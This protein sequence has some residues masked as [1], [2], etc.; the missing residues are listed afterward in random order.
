MVKNNFW[1]K[2]KQSNRPI[3]AL[4]PMAGFT[5]S[6]FRR[7]CHRFGADVLYSEM[8][9]ATALYYGEKSKRA[10][11]DNGA[12]ATY[13]LLNFDKKQ[14]GYYVV[15]LF[16]SNPE[17][18]AVAARLVTQKIKP[19]GID[20][21]FGCPAGKVI[22]Q[23]AGADLMKDLNR[24]R[25]VI[26]AVLVNTDLPVSV[27]IRARSADIG[28]LDFLR[29]I[30]DLP[31]A[32]VMIHGRSLSQGFI[33]DPDFELIKSARQYFSGIILA[34]GGINNLSQAQLALEKSAADGLGLARGVLGRPWLFAEIKSGRE[35]ELKIGEVFNLMLEQA[36]LFVA[37]KG[38]SALVEL[39]KHLVWYVQG[40]FGATDL[41][42]QL[43]K[44][45]TLEDLR[46]IIK[47]YQ[48]N[49]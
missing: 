45:N 49:L 44:I 40:M 23:G 9:S 21:N 38:E 37:L 1:E 20:I 29:H 25:A 18:F 43:V 7:L 35:Q 39:R 26:E 8:A 22:K 6:A 42:S 34:N 12:E 2:L 16:G 14:E 31:L 5:D 17:H 33:G 24:A 36:E 19:A 30:S 47:N 48:Y 4:A 28:A 41:R 11:R 27:K 15:Q 13:K 3:L 10:N 32:A 46:L